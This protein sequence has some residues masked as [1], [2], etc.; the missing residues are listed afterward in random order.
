MV[1]AEEDEGKSP[2]QQA[3]I[4]QGAHA[5]SSKADKKA[6]KEVDPSL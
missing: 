1:Q 2:V 3:A 6:H 5:E 4:D